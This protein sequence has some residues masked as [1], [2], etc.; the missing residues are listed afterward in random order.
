MTL[1][2]VAIA[3]DHAGYS[4]KEV[5]KQELVSMGHKP[6]DLGTDSEESV[7]YPDFAEK[8][9]VALQNKQAEYGV[10][11]CGSGIGISIAANRYNH[12][13]AALCSEPVSAYYARAHNDA[14]V[15]VFGAKFIGQ[16]VARSC[17]RVFLTTAFDGATVEGG[18][19]ER[20]V[21]KLFKQT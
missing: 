11:I 3:S 2:S 6:L 21:Q 4:F 17:L 18:R 14:N 16:E 19:H 9:A 15:I 12:I 1:I 20:R 8:L 7:D 10:L 13:R 5:I